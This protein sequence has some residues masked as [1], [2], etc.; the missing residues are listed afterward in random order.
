MTF[1]RG[2]RVYVVFVDHDLLDNNNRQ[3]LYVKNDYC[4]SVTDVEKYY[5][6]NKLKALDGI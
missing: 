5:K 6:N 3:F 4:L 2:A 1:E